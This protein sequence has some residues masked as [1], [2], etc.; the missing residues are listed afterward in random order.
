MVTAT[1]TALGSQPTAHPQEKEC[2]HDRH[3]GTCSACQRLAARRAQ[4]HLAAAA[5]ARQA[6]SERSAA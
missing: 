5:S 6:W 3:V 4:S 2:G 1:V